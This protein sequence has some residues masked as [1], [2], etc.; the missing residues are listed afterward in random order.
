MGARLVRF[1]QLSRRLRAPPEIV[2]TRRRPPAARHRPRARARRPARAQPRRAPRAARRRRRRA[3][4]TARPGGRRSAAAAPRPRCPRRARRATTPAARASPAALASPRAV[5]MPMR[6]PVNVPG[7]TP[8][9]IASSSPNSTPASSITLAIAGISSRACAGALAQAGGRRL[10]LE[11]RAV[12]AQHAGGAGGCRGVDAEQRHSIVDRDTPPV[13]AEVLQQH[14]R[15]DALEGGLA[16][17]GPLDERDPLGGQVVVQ[18][19]R[20][21]ARERAEPVQVEVGDLRRP[22][23]D[24]ADREGRARDGALDAR[25]RGRRR[26]RRSSCRCPARR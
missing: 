9:A 2:S 7:P 4:R 16:D 17:G 11:A 26:A 23:Q 19:R 18:Q 6:S 5:A 22:A 1:A 8:T 13:A 21:L 15:G 14:P 20:V 10:H 25:A 3:R 24:V 12:G